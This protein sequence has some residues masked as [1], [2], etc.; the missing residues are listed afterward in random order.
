MKY[1]KKYKLHKICASNRTRYAIHGVRYVPSEAILI[2]TN[3]RA[4]A[5]VECQPE[6]GD[7][8]CTVPRQ[9]FSMSE[10]TNVFNKAQVSICEGVAKIRRSGGE[11]S[12]GLLDGEYPD[13]KLIPPKAGRKTISLTLDLKILQNLAAAIGAEEADEDSATPVILTIG[14]GETGNYDEKA[15]MVEPGDPDASG[16]WGMTMPVINGKTSRREW[17]KK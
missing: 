5:V 15:I 13:Y 6:D 14:I 16:A 2:S 10:Q 7:K 4:M 11:L 1:D 12:A 9:M 3:G 17:E 8:E